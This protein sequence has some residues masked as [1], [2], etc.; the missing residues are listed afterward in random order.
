MCDVEL[1]LLD[2]FRLSCGGEAVALPMSAQRMLAF[3][4]L[5]DRPVLRSYVAGS[6]WLNSCERRAHANLRSALW[7]LSASGLRVIVASSPHL[8]LDRSVS[9]DLR[10]RERIARS[11]MLGG[12]S[13]DVDLDCAAL[14]ADLL[15]DWYDDWVVFERERYRQL[16]LGALET[17][18]ERLLVAGRIGEALDAALTAVAGEPLRESAHRAVMAVHIAHGNTGEAVRQ[19]DLFRDLLAAQ[20]GLEPSERMRRLKSS[21]ADHGPVLAR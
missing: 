18:C 15:P 1:R 13:G 7:R 14:A 5:S 17:L 3:V 10:E 21:L 6:L 20:L 2:T 11:L 4:A 16:R 12:G 19:H 9:V 8:V